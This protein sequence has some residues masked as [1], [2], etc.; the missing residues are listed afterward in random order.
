MT[1]LVTL[2]ACGNAFTN[3]LMLAT[4]ENA[5]G[6][7]VLDCR[8]NIFNISQIGNITF[9]FSDV[10]R[11]AA[12]NVIIN[13]TGAFSETWPASVVWQDQVT[14]APSSVTGLVDAYTLITVN[15]GASWLAAPFVQGA[16]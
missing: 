1:S 3:G 10:P 4:V 8:N 15:G 6:S 7:V 13:R 9:S 5:S 16:A 14:P 11:A 12:I 2:T